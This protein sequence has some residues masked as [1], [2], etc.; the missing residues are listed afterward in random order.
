MQR[1]FSGEHPSGSFLAVPAR[2]TV[3]RW[4]VLPLRITEL[5]K[6]PEPCY[7]LLLPAPLPS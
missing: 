5:S 1:K 2:I 7:G 3:A 6:R 4:P